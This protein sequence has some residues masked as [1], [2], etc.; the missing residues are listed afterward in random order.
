VYTPRGLSTQSRTRTPTSG[1]H[2]FVATH[3]VDTATSGRRPLIGGPDISSNR[4]NRLTAGSVGLGH[5]GSI[6]DTPVPHDGVREVRNTVA[7]LAKVFEEL[8]V[9]VRNP[10]CAVGSGPV[11]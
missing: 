10:K 5:A 9:E 8:L 6:V 4:W 11:Q 7:A 2:L 3:S 1:P